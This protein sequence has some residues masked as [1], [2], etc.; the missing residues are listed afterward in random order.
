MNE[1]EMQSSSNP[2]LIKI[3]LG[4]SILLFLI[5]AGTSI[6]NFISYS[7]KKLNILQPIKTTEKVSIQPG[8]NSNKIQKNNDI[9]ADEKTIERIKKQLWERKRKEMEVN[10]V[11]TQEPGFIYIFELKNGGNIKAD[12]YTTNGTSITIKNQ[13]GLSTTLNVDEISK[14]LKIKLKRN[15]N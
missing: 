10:Q 4:F 15:Q 6:K 11:P 14:I 9:V 8:I 13:S 1:K 12:N 3:L 5:F 7:L 2:Y